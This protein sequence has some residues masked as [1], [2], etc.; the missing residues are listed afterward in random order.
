MHVGGGVI[1]PVMSEV[2]SHLQ[3]E[4]C[5]HAKH[6]C[7]CSF[8][9]SGNQQTWNLIR[10]CIWSYHYQNWNFTTCMASLGLLILQKL[11]IHQTG[12]SPNWNFTTWHLWI[13]DSA[14]TRNWNFTTWYLWICW[15]YKN[16]KISKTG[17]SQHS[18]CGV[19]MLVDQHI[20]KKLS[21]PCPIL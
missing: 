12:N 11:E 7:N 13:A 18:I 1:T 14:K 9:E 4:F 15:F 2:T 6:V 21:D 16:W 3:A 10:W 8:C 5:K 17:T 20:K 19:A